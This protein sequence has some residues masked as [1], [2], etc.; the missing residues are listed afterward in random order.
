VTSGGM[1][2]VPTD[3]FDDEVRPEDMQTMDWNDLLD[4]DS[5]EQM[6]TLLHVTNSMNVSSIMKHGLQPLIGTRSQEANEFVPR[7]YAFPDENTMEDAITN[8]DIFD[9]DEP[10]SVL[11]VTVPQSWISQDEVE[12]EITIQQHVPP[13]MIKMYIPNIDDYITEDAQLPSVNA[14]DFKAIEAYADRLFAKV[15][16]DVD[17]TRHFR[18]RVNDS[19]NKNRPIT[20]AELTR[21][22]KQTFKKHGKVIPKLPEDS[23]ALLKDMSTDLNVPF[24]LVHDPRDGSMHLVSKTIIRNRD[25]RAGD[26]IFVVEDIW[27]GVSH[28]SAHTMPLDKLLSSLSDA[29]K[30][31]MGQLEAEPSEQGYLKNLETSVSTGMKTPVRLIILPDGKLHV[32]DGNHRM[33]VAKRLGLKEV[34]YVIDKDLSDTV[35]EVDHPEFMPG[36]DETR[37][38]SGHDST[39]D[40]RNTQYNTGHPAP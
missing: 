16:I 40:E 21:L 27:G 5:T 8:G 10:L 28:Q 35:T 36:G 17:F 37:G 25:Y 14:A 15:G 38:Y 20:A 3:P 19:R 12:W 31:F 39:Y 13:D 33:I 26:E 11:K 9:D 18:E 7:V 2:G 34:P 30:R 6:V 4:E 24:I 1:E 29:D 22:F 23:R 32:P